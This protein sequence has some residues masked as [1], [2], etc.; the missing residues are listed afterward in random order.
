MP[1]VTPRSAVPC[2][3]VEEVVERVLS[4]YVGATMARA[5][6]RGHYRAL[7]IGG[8]DLEPEQLDSLVQKV[9]LGL[10]IFVGRERTAELLAAIR[11]DL[12][13]QGAPA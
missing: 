12:D 5:A 2:Q 10:H 4:P 9:G 11:R 7:G 1:P 3:R 13:S 6:T 8:P